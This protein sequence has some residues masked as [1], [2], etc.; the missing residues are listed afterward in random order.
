MDSRLLGTDG[1]ESENVGSSEKPREI[2]FGFSL[3]SRPRHGPPRSVDPAGLNRQNLLGGSWPIGSEAY[4]L[5][6]F[7]LLDAHLSTAV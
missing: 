6:R 5:D 3:D 7:A 2:S 1:F 4:P